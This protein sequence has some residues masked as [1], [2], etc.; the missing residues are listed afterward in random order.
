M[1]YQTSSLAPA[2]APAAPAMPGGEK[3]VWASLGPWLAPVLAVA[4]AAGA[5]VVLPLGGWGPVAAAALGAA[6]AVA[7][8]LVLLRGRLAWRKRQGS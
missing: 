7:V 3:T 1:S 4:L 5:A 6:L 8:T 2:D